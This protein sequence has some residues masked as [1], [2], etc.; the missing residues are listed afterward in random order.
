VTNFAYLWMVAV[1]SVKFRTMADAE[2]EGMPWT[3]T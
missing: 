1:V 3:S 2:R